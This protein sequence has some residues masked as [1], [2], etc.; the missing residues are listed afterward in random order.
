MEAE[1]FVILLLHFALDAIY[2]ALFH[3]SPQLILPQLSDSASS[4][5]I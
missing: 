4:S 5:S 3:R 1:S 2:S